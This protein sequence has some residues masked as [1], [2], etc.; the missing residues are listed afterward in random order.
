[1]E[2]LPQEL[3][4]KSWKGDPGHEAGGDLL[5]L[6]MGVQDRFRIVAEGFSRK[7]SLGDKPRSGL[8][9]SAGPEQVSQPPFQGCSQKHSRDW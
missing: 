6:G 2:H 3:F 9:I 8:Q 7:G 5:G 1:M 4:S